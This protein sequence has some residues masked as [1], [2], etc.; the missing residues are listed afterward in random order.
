[1]ASSFL[2]AGVAACCLAACTVSAQDSRAYP[3]K[4]SRLV[5]P[6]P[7]GGGTDLLARA[8]AQGL[9]QRWGQQVIVDNRPGAAT[10]IGT[11]FV[12]RA[13]P[14]GYTML[15]AS[16]GH[17][18][19]VSLYQKLG[20]HPVK[21]FEMVTLVA[22]SPSLLVVTP[23]LPVKSVKELIAL[24]KRRP[25][26]LNYGSF[27]GGTSPHLSAELFNILAAVK[28]SH[29]PYKGSGPAL[30]S[31]MSGE[32]QVLFAT[33]LSGLPIVEAGRLR[34]LGVASAQ[35]LVALPQLPTVAETV[36]GFESGS[37]YGIMLP[38]GTPRAVVDKVHQDAVAVLR[39]PDV[40][41][42]FESEG[43]QIIASTPAELKAYLE[44]EI[45][46]WERVVKESGIKAAS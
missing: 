31:V 28:I 21:S 15:M 16:V 20:Y 29:V 42:R 24:A 36:P 38:A 37:W 25:G 46:R 10:N 11:E 26:E 5:V 30:T 6:F 19:N 27:G 7:P 9:S 23:S 2:R 39:Q 32:T 8:V 18:A 35:R 33:I 45:A 43:A 34:A 1:M 3:L 41:K 13:A 14:D 12:A 22:V 17:A 44:V 4:P 40:R